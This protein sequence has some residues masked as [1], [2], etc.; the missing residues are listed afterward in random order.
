MTTRRRRRT[1]RRPLTSIALR[2]DRSRCRSWDGTATFYRRE[3]QRETPRAVCTGR[4]VVYVHHTVW[5][6][7]NQFHAAYA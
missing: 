1:R 2:P 6:F 5:M 3:K 7:S 4:L